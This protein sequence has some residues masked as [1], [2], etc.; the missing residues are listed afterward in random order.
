[1]KAATKRWTTEPKIREDYER[2][3]EIFENDDLKPKDPSNKKSSVEMDP[4]EDI[5]DENSYEE[6][7]FSKFDF[8]KLLDKTML[9]FRHFH[10]QPVEAVGKNQVYE[11]S[12]EFAI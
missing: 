3:R 12:A 6:I 2:I 10:D 4:P 5:S 8:F 9:E 1:M 11:R 7:T